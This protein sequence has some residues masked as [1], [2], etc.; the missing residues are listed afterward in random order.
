V[1]GVRSIH[2]GAHAVGGGDGCARWRVE[3]SQG[4]VG[5]YGAA[6]NKARDRWVINGNA[7]APGGVGRE[8]FDVGTRCM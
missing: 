7:G 6:M 5:Y 8:T 1:A 2:A 3:T 4:H